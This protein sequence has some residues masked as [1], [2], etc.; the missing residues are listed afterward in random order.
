[1]TKWIESSAGVPE[2][3]GPAQTVRWAGR[4]IKL[5]DLSFR[6]LQLLSERAPDPV[7]FDEIERQVWAHVSRETIKQ[8]AK[9]LRDSLDELSI[10]GGGVESV[11]SVGYRLVRAF[12]AYDPKAQATAPGGR[13]R[14]WLAAVAGAVCLCIA[15]GA[16]LFSKAESPP[17]SLLV[18]VHGN[19][20]AVVTE[21]PLSAW[22]AAY[23]TLIKSLS[24]MSAIVVIADDGQQMADLVV[25]MDSIPD[26][27]FETLSL[28]LIERQTGTLFWAERV[29]LDQDGY[30][31]PIAAFVADV[32][33]QIVALGLQPGPDIDPDQANQARQHYLRASS[34]AKTDTVADLLAARAQLDT[35]LDLRPTYAIARS[36]RARINARLVTNHRQDRRLAL[37]AL[38]EAQSLADAHPDVPEFQRTLAAA[39]VAT[40]GTARRLGKPRK[41]RAEHAIPA[42]GRGGVEATNARRPALNIQK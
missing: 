7:S 4:E 5:P 37:Q 12:P 32:H 15:F 28:T 29:G 16:S 17:L 40:G 36:L 23:Q 41:G 1:M 9:L 20:P 10:P 14:L 42:S 11:R 13:R 6:L 33:R 34:L 22:D 31:K 19:A 35:A 8:R 3:C 30:D 38:D 24:R 25:A 18:S 26:G 21:F 27:P 2:L 39:Q